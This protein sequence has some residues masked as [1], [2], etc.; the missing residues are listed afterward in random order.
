MAGLTSGFMRPKKGTDQRIKF[1]E[2]TVS[3]RVSQT[4]PIKPWT[5][6]KRIAHWG[7]SPKHLVERL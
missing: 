3:I 2:P 1:E 5:H 4:K 6:S 7:T